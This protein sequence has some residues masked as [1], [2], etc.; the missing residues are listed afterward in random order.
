MAKDNPETENIFQDNLVDSYYPQRPRDLENIC[1]YANHE[2][3][4]KNDN[5]DR[6]Y[7]KITKPQ[8]PNYKLFD[9][10]KDN[11]T[12]Y[13]Y[14]SLLLLFVPLRD[15]SS[16]LMLKETAQEAFN[17]LLPTNVDCTRYH[18]KLLKMLK[19]Q[20]NIKKVNEARQADCIEARM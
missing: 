10:E 16:L 19:A 9:P 1:L 20:S 11:E 6:K 2:W 4:S 15:E 8:L 12:E 14:Y 13:Y 17:C 5:G 7:S 18:D 3:Y